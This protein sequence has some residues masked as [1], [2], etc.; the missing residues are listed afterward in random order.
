MLTQNKS[1]L[2]TTKSNIAISVI[3]SLL[4]SVPSF[5]WVFKDKSVWPWDQAWY[6]QLSVELWQSLTSNPFGWPHDMLSAFT[7]KAPLIAWLGQFAVPFQGL[8][9]RVEAALLT[10]NVLIGVASLILIY[11]SALFISSGRG[12]AAAKELSVLAVLIVGGAP[13][14]IALEHQYFVELLQVLSVAYLYWIWLSTRESPPT[15]K[16]ISHFFLALAIGLGAKSTTILYCILPMSGLLWS[17]FQ[18]RKSLSFGRTTGERIFLL[19]SGLTLLSVMAWYIFNFQAI[20]GFALQSSSGEVASHYGTKDSFINKMQYWLVAASTSL[21]TPLLLLSAL[22]VPII[23]L[24]LGKVRPVAK[25]S[26]PWL[27]VMLLFGQAVFPLIILALNINQENRYLL[28]ILPSYALL[29]VC[30]LQ[31]YKYVTRVF[32][33]FFA[34]QWAFANAVSFGLTESRGL[35][36]YWLME[37]KPDQHKHQMLEAIVEQVCQP[38]SSNQLFVVGVEYPDINYVSLKFIASTREAKCMFTSLGYS[39]D[40]LD[41]ATARI[42]GL[43]PSGVITLKQ[44]CQAEGA[45][46][47]NKISATFLQSLESENQYCSLQDSSIDECVSIYSCQW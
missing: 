1:S 38:A 29:V 41:H 13:L 32:I 22:L 44:E 36:N 8:F 25:D 43:K 19:V 11:Y 15:V 31:K 45:D 46:F 47:V 26:T 10:Y 3:I 2:L 4:L 30:L 5:I 12:N 40:N 21:A 20:L 24:I 14:F 33:F 42:K 6:G 7:I 39:E 18:N 27:L 16:H 9:P 35:T 28:P 37:F 23:F 17:I 34:C